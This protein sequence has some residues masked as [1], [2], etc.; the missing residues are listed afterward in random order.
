[1]DTTNRALHQIEQSG[2]IAAIR[3]R[4]PLDRMLEVGDALHATP[5]AAVM[6]S[7]GS[8]QPWEI[9]EELRHRYGASM[10]VGAGLL[11]STTLVL[12][13][14]DAGAQFIMT[15]GYVV[16]IDKLCRQR[17][18]LYAPGVRNA[19]AVRSVL[20]AGGCVASCFPRFG[21]DTAQ[22]AQIA[23]TYPTLHLVAMGGIGAWN[24]GGY[25]RAGVAAVVVR[26]AISAAAQWR[27][28]DAIVEMRRLRAL[29]MAAQLE[30]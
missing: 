30:K 27:M 4:A 11:A 25:A 13:A 18:V 19:D 28:H 14:T 24:L 10:L 29:W 6:I 23:Q 26:G 8:H 3:C 1:M 20:L 21:L 7:P 17:E 9:V 22:I 2:I 16:E 15:G 12:A 5:V